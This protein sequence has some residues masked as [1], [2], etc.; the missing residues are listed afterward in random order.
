MALRRIVVVGC[1]S[2]GRRHA[3]ILKNRTDIALELCEPDA[4]NLARALD[5]VGA[6]PTH[7]NFHEMLT[8]HPDMVIIATPHSLHAEQS[9]AA[10]SANIHVLCE[11]PMSDTLEN[12][13]RMLDVV[14]QSDSVFS[15]GFTLHFYPAMKAIKDLIASGELG[16]ILHAHWHIGTY[17]TLMNSVSRYQA[18]TEGALLLDYVH[19]PD[20]LYWWFGKQPT[21]VFAVGRQGGDQ[22]LQSNPNVLIMTI[23]YDDHLLATIHLNY[24]QNPQRAYCEIIGDKKSL[25]YDMMTG[26]IHLSDY[27]SGAVN[28]QDFAVNRDDLFVAEHQAFIDA[29]DGKRLPESPADEAIVSMKIIEA[30][31]ASWRQKRRINA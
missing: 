18:T 20:L 27:A 5:E 25:L 12:A 6:V 11:K 13:Q 17:I 29:V 4:V 2:I 7:T 30:A 19:Q 26:D 8:T 28:V 14:K 23:E 10:L 21:A 1:G 24:T 16:T 9:I 31:M 3:R 22:E 15:V